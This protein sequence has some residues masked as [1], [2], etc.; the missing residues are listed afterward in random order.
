MGMDKQSQTIEEL[1]GETDGDNK[2]STLATLPPYLG[3][4]KIKIEVIHIP[5][6]QQITPGVKDTANL[7]AILSAPIMTTLP[8]ADFLKVKPKLWEYV[9]EMMREQGSHLTKQMVSQEQTKY[10]METLKQMPF[11]KVSSYQEHNKDKGKFYV[12]IRV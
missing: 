7:H 1:K 3:D 11:N 8:L 5:K 9:V 4:Y 2:A 6:S 12:T 10:E